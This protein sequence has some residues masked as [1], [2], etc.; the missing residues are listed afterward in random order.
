MS[1]SK[2]PSEHRAEVSSDDADAASS[3]PPPRSDA[4]SDAAPKLHLTYRGDPFTLEM[5]QRCVGPGWAALVAE[6]YAA[7]PDGSTIQQVKEKFGGLRF[8]ATPDVEEIEEIE[9][10]SETICEDCGAAGRTR[11][12]PPGTMYG[13][14]RTL[15]DAC[16]V[17]K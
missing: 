14:L 16:A 4:E 12:T 17:P 9:A 3:A 5:A 10:R 11:N 2:Q 6:A 15:C 7:L 8:Y 13:W 1:V